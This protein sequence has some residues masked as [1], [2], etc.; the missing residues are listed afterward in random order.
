MGKANVDLICDIGELAGLFERSSNLDEFLQTA[1]SIVAWH[2][3]AAVCS[4]YLCEG[5]AETLVMRAN[6]GLKPSAIGKV[7]L[8]VGEGITGLALKEIRPIRAGQASTNPNFKY[9]PGIDE[10]KFEAFLAVPI[11]R[12]LTRIGVLVVQDP[13]ADY[14]DDND[15]KAL[16][17]IAAQLASTIE[18]AN[19]L[20]GMYGEIS[21]TEETEPVPV[22]KSGMLRGR[23]ASEGF[24]RGKATIIDTSEG[25]KLSVPA[26]RQDYSL[27]DFQNALKLTEE[28]LNLLQKETEEQLGDVASLIFSAHLLMLKD[29]QFSGL[30]LNKIESGDDPTR[31][32]VDVVNLYV[33]RFSTSSNQ[34]LREKIHDIKD[35]GYRLIENLTGASDHQVDY[36]NRIIVVAE[37]LPSDV[38]K[39]KAQ[40]AEGILLRGGGITS[41][42]SILGRSLHIPIIMVDDNRVLTIPTDTDLIMDANQGTIYIAPSEEIQATYAAHAETIRSLNAAEKVKSETYTQDGTRIHL[43]AN[44][45]LISDLKVARELKAEGIGL[46]RSEFPFIV[47]DSFPTEEEQYVIYRRIVE[48][49]QGKEITFRTLDVG[50]DKMLSYYSTVHETNPFLGLRAI[51]FSLRNRHIFSEQLRAM[52]RAGHDADTRIMFPLISSLDDF[53]DARTVVFEC[54]DELRSKGVPF[55][56]KIRL[57]VMVELPSAIEIIDELAHLA[58]FL[59]IGTNDLVQYMLAV[60]RTNEQISD[61]YLAHHPAVLRAMKRVADA[62]HRYDTDLSICGDLARDVKL[63][64][65]LLGIGIKKLSIEPLSIYSVQQEIETMLISKTRNIADNLLHMARVKDI[66]SYLASNL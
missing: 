26:E 42:V 55:N 43:M 18:N 33:D 44:I 19:L 36:Q 32:I 1:V 46:Y 58:D 38:V 20:L 53:I 56:E 60:D 61:L 7:R 28:Q 14:F 22:I 57:G 25:E 21:D 49:M 23:S 29:T 12:G 59:S 62:S 10:E 34:R 48:D 30:I 35:V 11:V 63:I 8:N 16:R 3:K 40:K 51:R 37:A 2:M 54:M 15:A 5:D 6:Q 24:A 50:G 47:R 39:Y 4:I 45:N 31:A 27:D 17:A 13:Q 41:H 52:L 65:F 9:I 66:E 64:P